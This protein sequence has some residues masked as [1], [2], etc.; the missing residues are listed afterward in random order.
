[1][2][3]IKCKTDL[4]EN[5]LYCNACGWKQAR[6]PAGRKPR[7]RGNGTGTVFK[8]AGG[9]WKAEVTVGK[10]ISKT[11]GLPAPD[12]RSKS[13]FK[14]KKDALEYLPMLRQQASPASKRLQRPAVTL[15]VLWKGYS[16]SAMLKLSKSKQT[17]YKTAYNK[18]EYIADIPIA[19]LT[20]DDL[21]D[22]V[23]IKAPTFYPAKDMKAVLSHLY[24]RAAAQQDVKT[25]LAEFI[26]L[27]ALDEKEPVPFTAEEQQAL[28]N[29]YA[30]GNTIT[31]YILLM[32]YTGMMPG[33]LIKCRKDMI[34][35]ESQQ[36]LGC[37]LKTKKRKETPI[38]LADVIMPVLENLCELSKTEF[39][40]DIRRD[41]FYKEF[42]AILRRC[43]CRDL[44]PYACRHTTAT[45]LAAEKIDPEII[46]EI[47][48]HTKF[49]TTQRYI[50]I[51]PDLTPLKD[52]LNSLNKQT[53]EQ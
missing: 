52:A 18:L 20:I 47:M 34:D 22:I 24:T 21:Q 36:I 46:R 26:V 23:E 32:I 51:V 15:S 50:H 5:S 16:T 38:V 4:P 43:K 8:T 31:G 29:D 35:W 49:S 1:M 44:T 30:G 17:H 19:E 42:D 2:F 9:T 13:G 27:P 6:N 7:S 11:T 37:G 14:T 10:K 3:C 41:D 53:Q 39:L 28:W 12:R 48:R 25:N 45:A 40:L 33:E